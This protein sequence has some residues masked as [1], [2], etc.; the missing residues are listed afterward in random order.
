M[1][2]LPHRQI[3]DTPTRENFERLDDRVTELEGSVGGGGPPTGAA[4]GQ[5]D[6]TY[7]DPDIATSVAGAGLAGGGG[8]PISVGAGTGVTVNANDVAVDTGVIATLAAVATGYQPLDSDLTA[9]AALATTAFGRSVLIQAD[10]AAVRTLIDAPSNAE[11]VLDTIIDAKGDLLAGTAAD[12][13]ARLAI[14]ANGT[15]LT[16]DSAETTGMKWAAPAGGGP[17]SGAAGGQLAGTYPDP[18]I[19]AAVAGAGLTGAG[20]SPL[21]VGAGTGI[22]V[23]A[24]DVAVDTSVIATLAAVAAGY[25]P[26]DSDL[27]AIAALTTTAYGRGFLDLADAA[28]GRTK[29]GLGSLAVLS[30]INDGNW[31][32]TD[33]AVANGGTGASTAAA[34]RTNLDVPSNAEAILDALIDAKGDLIVGTAADTPARLAIG[35]T[36]GHVLQIDA[37]Q[38]SGMKWAA[39]AGGGLSSPVADADL[40]SPNNAAYKTIHFQRGAVGNDNTA[41]THILIPSGNVKS[42]VNILLANIAT[43]TPMAYLELDDADYTVGSKTTKLRLTALIITNATAP[44]INFTFGLYPVTSAGAADSITLTLGVVVAGSTV[45]INTPGASTPTR[46]QGADFNVPADG[47]YLLGCVTSGTIANNSLALM[48]ARVQVRNV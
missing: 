38:A 24:N 21:A 10:A 7:P 4:G 37:A 48:H 44:A 19:A 30:T 3:P 42:G 11:A 32:G 22:T 46:G 40:E 16:A 36:D 20:G 5:L 12:T 47:T 45:A 39:G 14:G 28:A 18:N 23:N 13:I 1:G 33:L 6:G 17:P 29:L 2:D 41:G 8:S 9:I 34:A 15:V 27:T 43:Q 26:L 25:Q 31:S 35:A